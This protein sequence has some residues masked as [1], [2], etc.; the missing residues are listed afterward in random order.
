[1]VRLGPVALLSA[2]L[3]VLAACGSDY[4][5]VSNRGAGAF[6]KVPDSW[7]LYEEGDLLRAEDDTV[8]DDDL[9]SLQDRLWLRGFDGDDDPA[10]EHVVDISARSPRG[11]AEVRELTAG[12]RDVLDYAAM[13]KAGFP[14]QDPSTGEVMDPLAY[15]DQNPD[16]PVTVLEYED[17]D[18]LGTLELGEGLRGVRVLSRIAL[19]DEEPVILE[20]VTVVDAGTRRRYT[21]T[22]GC[23]QDCWDANEHV[24]REIADSWTLEEVS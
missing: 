4:R 12:E 17:D 10:P 3:L 8:S 20:Q 6:F 2:G 22:V 7:H 1:M 23:T 14:L 24:I 19:E 21:F 15:A 18:T 9:E 13:R 16:G 11:Y 5:Y